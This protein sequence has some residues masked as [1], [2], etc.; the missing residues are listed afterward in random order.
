[1]IEWYWLIPAVVAA[2]YVGV[3][4]GL[5]VPYDDEN[6]F[7]RLRKNEEKIRVKYAGQVRS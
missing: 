4:I 5:N 1:M 3:V 2:G 6:D 7:Y